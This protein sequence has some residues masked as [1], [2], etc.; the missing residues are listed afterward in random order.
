MMISPGIFSKFRFF[1]L[2]EGKRARNG[3]KRQKIMS[4]M[5]HI[6]GTMHHMIVLFMLQIYKMIIS[7]GIFFIFSKFRFVGFLG[8]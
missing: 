1:G 5:L 3:P 7:S 2:L 4:V 8:G 6:S